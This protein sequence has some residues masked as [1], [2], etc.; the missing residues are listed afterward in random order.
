[1]VRTGPTVMLVSTMVDRAR[2]Y[3]ALLRQS[4]SAFVQKCFGTLEP[5]IAYLHNWHIDHVCWQLSRVA[6]GQVRRLIVTMPPRSGKSITVS[7][8]FPAWMLGHNR[9]SASWRSRMEKSSPAS[10]RST[11]AVS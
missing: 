11:P 8:A 7:V 5:G 6:S 4:M 1:M 9:Q 3:H 2:L 10:S